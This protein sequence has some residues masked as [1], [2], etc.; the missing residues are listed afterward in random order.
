MVGL[1]G[2]SGSG[3]TTFFRLLVGALR[4]SQG[5]L[6][7]LG[8]PM[9][10]ARTG[11]LRRLRRRLALI[12][13]QHNLVP[14]VSVVRNVLFGRLGR[15]PL[16]RALR[17]SVH[18][19]A[20]ERATVYATLE[21]LGIADKLYQRVDELSGGQQQRVAVARA[22]LDPPELLLADEPIASVDADT[23]ALVLDRFRQ[24]N[25]EYGTTVLVSLHQADFARRY[26]SRV[27]VLSHGALVYDGSPADAPVTAA[28][29]DGAAPP[30]PEPLAEQG[31]PPGACRPLGV[32]R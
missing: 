24:I 15:V 30:E 20:A 22:L 23:A 17:W 4:P 31:L 18:L 12:Y 14:S 21:D 26:C 2:P 3:K 9:E 5:R 19:S 29:S 6:R 11:E 16:W 32:A 7:V 28:R 10:S 8:Q 13:Q 25:R 1:L 27:L